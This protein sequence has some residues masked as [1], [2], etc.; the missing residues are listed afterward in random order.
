MNKDKQFKLVLNQCETINLKKL[1]I[2]TLLLVVHFLLKDYK[3]METNITPD[4][5]TI[6]A[7]KEE[8]TFINT[9]VNSLKTYLDNNIIVSDTLFYLFKNR[10][11]SPLYSKITRN[12]E[13]M[14]AY[15]KYLINIFSTKLSNGSNWIPELLAF[16]LIY[17]YKKEH[18]KSFSFFPEIDNFPMDKLINIY[19]KNNLELKKRIAAEDNISV[20]KVKTNIDEMYDTS[21]VMVKKYLD[22]NFKINESRVSK[23][24]VSKTRVKRKK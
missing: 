22:Y 24:R 11:Q 18:D 5:M 2:N 3:K 14:K 16:S 1:K 17:N 21:E 10:T 20:W 6:C 8:L 7:S 19:N 12:L 23:T 15:Y 9:S 13:P 4:P